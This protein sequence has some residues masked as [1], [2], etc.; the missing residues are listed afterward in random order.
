M[1]HQGLLPSWGETGSEIKIELDPD[2]ERKEREDID[3]SGEGEQARK[4]RKQAIRYVN[5][6]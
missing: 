2:T 4:S 3:Q 6:A 5:T 1:T